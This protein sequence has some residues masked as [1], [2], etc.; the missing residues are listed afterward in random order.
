MAGDGTATWITAHKNTQS[1]FPTIGADVNHKTLNFS[2]VLRF[3]TRRRGRSAGAM[4][5]HL[6]THCVQIRKKKHNRKKNV[7]AYDDADYFSELFGCGEKYPF[8]S[9]GFRRRGEA[10]LVLTFWRRKK[11]SPLLQRCKLRPRDASDDSQNI[12]DQHSCHSLLEFIRMRYGVTIRLLAGF[13]IRCHARLRKFCFD[14]V[15]RVDDNS[16]LRYSNDT[17]R[18][19]VYWPPPPTLPSPVMHFLYSALLS[20]NTLYILSF[21]HSHVCISLQVI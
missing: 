11:K 12:L 5:L 4:T 2:R 20:L 14:C 18:A 7:G 19:T 9:S 10:A 15:V 17:R 8:D 1:S 13:Y 3:V 6:N 21:S 16:V